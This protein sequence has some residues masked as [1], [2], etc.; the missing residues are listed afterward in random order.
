MHNHERLGSSSRQDGNSIRQDGKCDNLQKS[1]TGWLPG[2]KRQGLD[3]ESW[4]VGD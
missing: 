1:M 3:T 4:R 2:G